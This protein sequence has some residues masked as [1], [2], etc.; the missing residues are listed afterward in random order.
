MQ[1]VFCERESSCLAG[2]FVFVLAGWLI[3]LS[4]VFLAF[5][6][7]PPYG[8]PIHCVHAFSLVLISSRPRVTTEVVTIDFGLA[9]ALRR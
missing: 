7:L 5:L 2:F 3:S 9:P 4:R 8:S 1:V 6:Q